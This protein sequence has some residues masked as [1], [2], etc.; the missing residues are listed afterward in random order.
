MNKILL[1]TVS[2]A[3]LFCLKT[4]NAVCSPPIG[5]CECAYPIIENGHLACGPTY[6]STGT[7]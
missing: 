2:V 5:K 7:T 3:G 6:C 4:A 1:L